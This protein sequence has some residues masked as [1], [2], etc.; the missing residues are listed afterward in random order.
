MR[1]EYKP[2]NEN[3]NTEELADQLKETLKG[4]NIKEEM[5]DQLSKIKDKP[6]KEQLAYYARYYGIA[7]VAVVVVLFILFSIIHDVASK[8]ET[9]FKAMIVNATGL[10]AYSVDEE[11]AEYAGI[12]LNKYACD[13]DVG[14]FLST[15]GFS[16]D[17]SATLTRF[18]ADIQTK[19][20]DCA[21]FHSER[22]YIDSMNMFYKDLRT[23]LPEADL[24]RF[25]EQFYYIDYAEYEKMDKGDISKPASPDTEPTLEEME[26]NL[27]F[28]RDPGNMSDPIPVGIIIDDCPYLT[29]K[30]A[31]PLLT[32]VYG[33]I[34]NT[35]REELAIQFLHFLYGY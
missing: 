29:E 34:I 17:D 2:D 26:A 13:I 28:H 25:K 4:D 1:L 10:S 15:S 14:S 20:M 33:I 7:A 8:K 6:L 31:Y 12:D 23:V 30:N 24:E 18:V 3:T 5:K 22:F 35:E 9:A 16:Y 27:N 11:F 21:I 19:D 32:P